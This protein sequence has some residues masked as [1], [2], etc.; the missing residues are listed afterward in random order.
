[1]KDDVVNPL[2][3]DQF[4]EKFYWRYFTSCTTSMKNFIQIRARQV[5]KSVF[6]NTKFENH[7]CAGDIAIIW[8]GRMN[9][10]LKFLGGTVG[11]AQKEF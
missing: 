8:Q 7:L 6:E 5:P 10:W 9:H 1:M 2:Q 11:D 3:V 4:G